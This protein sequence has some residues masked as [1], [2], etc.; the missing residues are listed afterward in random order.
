MGAVSSTETGSWAS[1]DKWKKTMENVK[2]EYDN[3]ERDT[4]QQK[5]D[6]AAQSERLQAAARE[7]FERRDKLIDA[8]YEALE[9]F[10]RELLTYS[11]GN[12]DIGSK[13]VPT[14]PVVVDCFKQLA[15]FCEGVVD[16]QTLEAVEST[17]EIGEDGQIAERIKN[18]GEKLKV[19][20][21]GL[22]AAVSKAWEN[23]EVHHGH[24]ENARAALR[25]AEERRSV[26]T[27]TVLLVNGSHADT[28]EG[29]F[30][31]VFGDSDIDNAVNN[32][33]NNEDT[34]HKSADD[35]WAMWDHLRKLKD[36]HRSLLDNNLGQLCS[37]LTILVDGMRAN[38]ANIGASRKVDR[39]CWL[40]ARL[41]QY[42]VTTNNEYTSRDD[43]LRHVFKL[44]HTV[45]DSIDSDDDVIRL[46][47]VIEN[48]V[49]QTL[50][51]TKAEELHR[52]KVFLSNPDEVDF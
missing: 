13:A 21:N 50:G 52:E 7:A 33:R 38:Y 23:F 10:V 37:E 2:T 31:D 43:A 19:T 3:L 1:V 51:D 35:A 14:L 29:F 4:R 48:N 28:L 16:Q 17:Q 41:L 47:G 25:Q 44:V 18:G 20:L 26:R 24:H 30:Y 5:S 39:E 8:A 6:M 49:R 9:C 34:W 45:N 15:E 12:T 36:E 27:S 11:D 22:D 46:K 32:C 42:H 40:A